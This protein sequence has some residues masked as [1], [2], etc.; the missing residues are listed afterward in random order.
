MSRSSL[1]LLGLLITAVSLAQK[2]DPMLMHVIQQSEQTVKA[3]KMRRAKGAAPARKPMVLYSRLTGDRIVR[4]ERHVVNGVDT[5]ELKQQLSLRFNDDGT[6]RSVVVLAELAEGAVVPEARL[7]AMGIRYDALVART[8]ILDVPARMLDALGELPEF[9]RLNASYENRLYND[10][11]RQLV[12][13]AY[14]T[15]E[16]SYAPLTSHYD[17][18]GVVVGVIDQGIDFNHISFLD[19]ETGVTRVKEAVYFESSY[20]DSMTVVTDAVKIGKLT[21]KN[22]KTSHGTHVSATAAGS[23]V[24]VKRAEDKT[25]VRCDAAEDGAVNVQGIAPKA[26]LVLCDLGSS[27]SDVR[28]LQATQEIFRY[29]ESVG[30]PAVVNMS[31]GR[32]Y[33][34]HDGADVGWANL[35]APGRIVCISAG[36]EADFKLSIVKTL[37]APAEDDYQ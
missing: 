20:L 1:T 30:K 27:L 17:G 9:R 4:D 8:A 31:F 10:L 7:A 3:E 12:S 36:N 29:A 25:S 18:T 5:M 16:Q 24:Y 13:S 33:S 23:P 2:I 35:T 28:V 32:N 21:A 34:L 26:D 37:G 15:G 11:T 19:P 22:S 6:V 14:V